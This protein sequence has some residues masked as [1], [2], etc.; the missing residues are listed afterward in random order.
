MMSFPGSIGMWF[1]QII[2]EF[3]TLSLKSKESSAVAR[4]AHALKT[5]PKQHKNA[6]LRLK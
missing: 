1:P 6:L 3:D 4:N 2:S 5:K